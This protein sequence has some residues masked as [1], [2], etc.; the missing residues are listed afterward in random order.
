[1]D[2]TDPPRSKTFESNNNHKGKNGNRKEYLRKKAQKR[3]IITAFALSFCITAVLSLGSD[4]V[5]STLDMAIAIPVLLF[6]IFTGIIFDA[7]G[8]AVAVA[9]IKPFNSMA[10][11]RMV[12]GKKAVWLISNAEKV[13]SFCNDL[14]GDICGVMSGATGTA[15]AARLFD[16]MASE[17][18][19]TLMMTS[20][21]SAM[22]VGF[23]AIG[24]LI[25]VKHS[26]KIVLYTAKVMCGFKK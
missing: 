5:V 16:G 4:V 20:L 25:A 23:K 9:D 21:I 8:L 10:A 26:E 15:I 2:K 1:M 6:F 11:R 18:W 7:V 13:G 17:V 19:L 3:W 14:V 12:T 24:K 22:M